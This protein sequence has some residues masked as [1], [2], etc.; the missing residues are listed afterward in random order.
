MTLRGLPF[1]PMLNVSI[2]DT[3]GV[4][5]LPS[6]TLIQCWAGSTLIGGEVEGNFYEVVTE[7]RSRVDFSKLG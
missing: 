4:L 6:L 1:A 3:N 2:A 7:E 5:I